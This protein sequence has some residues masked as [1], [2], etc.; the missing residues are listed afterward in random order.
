MIRV[1]ASSW[2]LRGDRLDVK[3][4]ALPNC[5]SDLYQ[6]LLSYHIGL[7]NLWFNEVPI[8]GHVEETFGKITLMVCRVVASS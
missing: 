2:E 4:I 6:S 5:T 7:A 8:V 3:A 1:E